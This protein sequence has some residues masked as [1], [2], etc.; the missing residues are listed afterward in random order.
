MATQHVITG[1]LLKAGDPD[2]TQTI[3]VKPTVPAKVISANEQQSVEPETI[4]TDGVTG[5][6]TIELVASSDLEGYSTE[7]LVPYDFIF[8]SGTDSEYTE[9]RIVDRDGNFNDLPTL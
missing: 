1:T 8:R 7:K 5:A 4:T 9:Q 2:I 3:I 6:W